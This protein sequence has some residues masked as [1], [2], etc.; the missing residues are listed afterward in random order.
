VSPGIGGG[1]HT[2]ERSTGPS[3]NPSPQMCPRQSI[4]RPSHGRGGDGQARPV[5][6]A[7]ERSAGPC[8]RHHGK[9]LVC[10]ECIETPAYQ[11]LQGFGWYQA[12]IKVGRSTTAAEARLPASS[13]SHHHTWITPAPPVLSVHQ[14]LVY[15]HGNVR[16]RWPGQGLAS[17]RGAD[18]RPG[19]HAAQ[20]RPHSGCPN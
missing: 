10:L 7:P 6:E 14:L 13:S 3:P 20:H 15:M 17:L 19:E 12:E 1:R 11:S 2:A 8:Q 9:A 18:S 4:R 16:R 5:V